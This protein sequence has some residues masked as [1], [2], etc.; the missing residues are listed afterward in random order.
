MPHGTIGQDGEVDW[1]LLF[2]PLVL[3]LLGPLVFWLIGYSSDGSITPFDVCVS[4]LRLRIAA[5]GAL[6]PSG[7]LSSYKKS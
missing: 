7:V 2:G 3:L 4:T 1:L 6:R 5:S